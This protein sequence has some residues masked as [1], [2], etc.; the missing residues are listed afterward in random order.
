MKQIIQNF[1][2]KPS[3]YLKDLVSVKRKLFVSLIF[4]FLVNV[5]LFLVSIRGIPIFSGVVAFGNLP[6]FYLYGPIPSGEIEQ[7]TLYPIFLQLLSHIFGVI[8]SPSIVYFSSIFLPS[9]AI[10]FLVNE[11]TNHKAFSI[12][13]AIAFGTSVNP[14]ELSQL[15]SGSFMSFI[16]VFFF[17]LS[18]TFLIKFFR[19]NQLLYLISSAVLYALAT[20]SVSYFPIGIYLSFPFILGFFYIHTTKGNIKYILIRFFIFVGI[21]AAFLI[22][23]SLP[24][25]M[26]NL[27]ALSSV[28][29]GSSINN[30][31][32]SV[33]YYEYSHY[34]IINTFLDSVYNSPNGYLTN[35]Y[36]NILVGIFI[37]SAFLFII[38]KLKNRNSRIIK[39]GF[40]LFLFSSLIILLFHYHIFLN[41][42]LH[43]G[44]FDQ[45]D[46][47]YDF[48]YVQQIAIIIAA[49]SVLDV[50]IYL[51]SKANEF[52]S[53]KNT[54]ITTKHSVF[55][56]TKRLKLSASILATLTLTF[57]LVLSSYP[58]VINTPTDF[59]IDQGDPFIPPS[60]NAIHTF[61]SSHNELD[62]EMLL[63]PNTEN[64]IFSASEIIPSQ[65][66][67]NP[68]QPLPVYSDRYNI[69][70]YEQVLSLPYYGTVNSFG[71][72]LNLSG[73]HLLLVS[74]KSPAITLIPD[75][76]T[77]SISKSMFINTSIFLASLNNSSS[78]SLLYRISDLYL[79]KVIGNLRYF[80][81]YSG[82]AT[83]EN[84]TPS[85]I[86]IGNIFNTNDYS[87][88]S[89]YMKKYENYE[90]NH[91]FLINYNF[92]GTQ[93][94][95]YLYINA[96][97][98]NNSFGGG[99]RNFCL[100]GDLNITGHDALD[101]FI[102]LYNNSS[103]AFLNETSRINLD[104]INK[105]SSFS[106]NFSVPKYVLS[107]NVVFY[108]FG[109]DSSVFRL[110]HIK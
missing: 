22:P 108:V 18:L 26:Q 23:E 25:I 75:V 90:G 95:N 30:Y 3:S 62:K 96:L 35:I 87:N 86:N 49:I 61:L 94:Y 16:W 5:T 54:D 4:I 45:L 31:V 48:L 15:F 11:L 88:F 92:S 65:Y 73:V 98:S 89:G 29:G 8:I 102:M 40:F 27:P 70:A 50:F 58:V 64:M 69:T 67:W 44:V 12:F 32:K 9:F 105:N 110:S 84:A 10:F 103:L 55:N 39:L 77:Y 71:Y 52:V 13:V 66:I 82:I 1:I 81:T 85:T 56:Q 104:V 74:G 21:S 79:Y 57:I 47:P 46:Y 63:L 42:F 6:A 53:K 28:S 78:F 83:F 60:F 7:L 97:L 93:T 106:L 51:L 14:L 101:M 80:N 33:I 91:N 19:S 43:F 59:H 109:R 100:T 34:T 36:W 68:P 107:M 24:T 37:T 76:P 2:I 17:L 38:L 72:M 41:Q 20:T 99:T